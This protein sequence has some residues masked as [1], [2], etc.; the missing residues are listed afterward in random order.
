MGSRRTQNGVVVATGRWEPFLAGGICLVVLTGVGWLLQLGARL[1]SAIPVEAV[2]VA[3]R[4]VARVPLPQIGFWI[5]IGVGAIFVLALI[6]DR[7]IVTVTPQAISF[8]RP[9]Q[10]PTVERVRI[11]AVFVEEQYLVLLGARGEQLA[12]ERYDASRLQSLR[13]ALVGY[14]YPWS[15]ERPPPVGPWQT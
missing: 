15:L 4:V 9:G 11:A 10:G 7:V 2:R 5:G 8:G 3:G 6:G 13:E 1:V 14:E 12:R